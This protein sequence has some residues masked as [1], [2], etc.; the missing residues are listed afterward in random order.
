M[1]KI[2]STLKSPANALVLDTVRQNWSLLLINLL[3]NFLSALLEGSTLGLIFLAIAFI[4]DDEKAQVDSS[5]IQF[6]IQINPAHPKYIFLLLIV[7]AVCL[8]IFLSLSKYLNRVSASYLSAKAQPLVTGKIF[9]RIMSFGYSCVSRY[10]VGDLLL[11]VNDASKAI[12]T[13]IHG[14]NNLVV[15]LSF[16]AIYLLVIVKLSPILA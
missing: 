10:K 12:D 11:F 14:L 4:S 5:I 9:E 6:L 7:G 1:K 16:S 2:L 13:Q 15:C 8:Q 3:T